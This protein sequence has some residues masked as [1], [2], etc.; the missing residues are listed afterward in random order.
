MLARSGGDPSHGETPRPGRSHLRRSRRA[1]ARSRSAAAGAAGGTCTTGGGAWSG[2]SSP[3]S[4]AGPSPR[5]TRPTC[6]RSSRR[7]GTSRRRRPGR[8]ASASAPC[9]SGPSPSTC[10]ATIPCDRVVP[11]LG[12]Q[13][14]I[15]TH[16]QALR[17][18]DVAAAI[19]TV[20]DGSAQPAVRLAFE[21]LVLTAA[22][23]GEVRHAT[24]DEVDTAGAV[25]TVP[26]RTDEGEAR[27]PGPALR[28]C[29]GSPRRGADA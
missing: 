16:R 28:A 23:S 7:S 15:V 6:W 11:V 4:A 20:R 1:R 17:H 3:A 10:A 21:F 9:W 24:W 13:N 27:A 12:P 8:S 26:G 25:W 19:G 2:T 22:R 29:A 5:S 14:D 18:Q